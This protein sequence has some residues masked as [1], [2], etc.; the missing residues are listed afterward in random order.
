MT[1]GLF[2]RAG[3]IFMCD[4]SDF[5]PPEMTKVRPVIVISPKLP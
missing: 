3:E 4:F 2:P 5:S 1:L